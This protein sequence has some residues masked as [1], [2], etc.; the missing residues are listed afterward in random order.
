MLSHD[1]LQELI[2]DA[3]AA[4][5]CVRIVLSKP[6]RGGSAADR[7]T[8]RPVDLAGGTKYQFATRTGSRETHENV[9]P[10]RVGERVMALFGPVFEH[11]HLLTTEADH[12]ARIG[13]AGAVHIRSSGPTHAAVTAEHDQPKQYLI[14]EGRPCAFLAGIGVMTPAGQVRKA[15]YA[16]FR[17]VNRFLE[18]V[19]DIV[20]FLPAE[21]RLTVVDYGC[22]K[23][24]LT[25]ALYHLL[26][27]IHGREVQITGLDRNAEVVRDCA[28]L[29]GRLGCRGL[30]FFPGDIT[31]HDVDGPIDLAVSLHACDTAT[32]DALA[33]AVR[34][35][36]R[37][38]LAVPCCQHELAPQL[39]GA[40]FGPLLRHGIVR[41]R[42]AAL[43][44]DALR[45]LMLE[46]HG[47]GT[48]IVEFVDLEHTAKNVLLRA[49]RHAPSDQQVTAARRAY[50]EF[51]TRFGLGRT[52]LDRAFGDVA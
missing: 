23:S 17:Q 48:Q 1:R 43:V 28:E 18:L 25:F 24:S 39:A 44:T 52:H 20:A 14:P 33:H 5:T 37:V 40:D 15:R 12:A 9:D 32:D 30:E 50:D 42:L 36:A 31:S 4:G 51:K 11:C 21:G 16:K 27:E 26:A 46:I 13:R 41:E 19:D 8:V 49:V 34:R 29:A 2:A 6:R 10:A 45:A 7:V 22:G 38:I 47:Y 35:E 3:V